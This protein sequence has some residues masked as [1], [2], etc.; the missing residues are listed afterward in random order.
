MVKSAPLRS[1]LKVS[2]TCPRLCPLQSSP[3][4][5]RYG[6]RRR[7]LGEELQFSGCLLQANPPGAFTAVTPHWRS[8]Q[9]RQ[10]GLGTCE[11]SPGL[12]VAGTLVAF[13]VQSFALVAGPRP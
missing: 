8:L 2:L 5:R 9:S 13:I 6:P 4:A 11:E 1:Y 12:A 10:P 3:Q 7:R